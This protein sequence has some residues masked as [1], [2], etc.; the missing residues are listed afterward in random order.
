MEVI[1]LTQDEAYLAMINF[2]EDTLT[3]IKSDDLAALLGAMDLNPYDN[4]PMDPALWSDWLKAVQ[5][6]VQSSKD[7]KD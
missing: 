2:L 7:S 6:V 1:S 5:K 4:K 3:R